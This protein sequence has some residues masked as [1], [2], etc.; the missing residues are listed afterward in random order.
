MEDSA[1]SVAA[2]SVPFTIG[3]EW[4]PDASFDQQLDKLD[5][6]SSDLTEF[7][8]EFLA[9][10]PSFKFGNPLETMGKTKHA[11]VAVPIK[12]NGNRKQTNPRPKRTVAPKRQSAS[13]AITR[14]VAAPVALGYEVTSRMPRKFSTMR[15]CRIIHEELITPLS[16]YS[17]FTIGASLSINP[18]L[19]Q[20][21]P[22]LSTQAVGWEQYRFNYLEFVYVPRSAT[23]RDGVISM[24]PDYDAADTAPLTEAIM[25]TYEGYVQ[26]TP[27]SEHVCRL[28]PR[29][30]F[31]MGNH[32]FV[33]TS[34]LSANLDVK[35]Y[36]AGN[37][38]FAT[39]DVNPTGVI[40]RLYVRYD[41]EFL[42]PQLPPAG[43][44]TSWSLAS[45]GSGITT[46]A[47]FGTAPT[48]FGT[49]ISVSPTSP[50]TTIVFNSVGLW[51]VVVQMTGTGVNG[52]APTLS[53]T[54]A[55]SNIPGAGTQLYNTAQTIGTLALLVTS[56]AV[57]QYLT[58]GSYAGSCTTLT[59]FTIHAAVYSSSALQ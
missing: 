27:W 51:L 32:K 6:P 26:G 35:T 22:W 33:R 2:T 16:G 23:S 42:N 46:T 28:G 9:P 17:S 44:P 10:L 19:A 48:V 3:T 38:Y 49:T 18:G 59:A 37:F 12:R 25:S 5:L 57:G 50:Y 43:V 31:S 20:T 30:M 39:A 13:T 24:A 56:T 52:S 7:A 45:G 1:L 34:A 8:D 36:D 29:K 11:K 47:P 54:I 21:F 41:V 14:P 15:N 58:F 40:G 4:R 53:G 55:L